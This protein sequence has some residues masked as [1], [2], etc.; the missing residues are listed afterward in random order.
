MI[1]LSV[2]LFLAGDQFPLGI[3][4]YAFSLSASAM[5]TSGSR[6]DFPHFPGDGLAQRLCPPGEP[7][8]PSFRCSRPYMHGCTHGTRR[9]DTPMPSWH[10][11][12]GRRGREELLPPWG[13]SPGRRKSDQQ[14][15]L[16]K[17]TGSL[18]RLPVT[19]D[20]AFE[21]QARRGRGG[22][23]SYPLERGER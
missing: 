19:T 14:G 4:R 3:I 12:A 21:R 6:E 15:G 5:P 2:G 13:E 23:E 10:L 8:A 17:E 1:S 16:E 22:W 11:P 20:R 9:R 7:D 18:G